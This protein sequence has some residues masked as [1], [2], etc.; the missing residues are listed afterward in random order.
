MPAS[1]PTPLTATEPA[2]GS[3][4]DEALA[5]AWRHVV[6]ASNTSFLQGMRVLPP[7][8]RRAMYAIYAFCRE[9]DDIADEP[10][11]IDDKR[12]RLAEWRAEIDRLFAGRPTAP[13]ARALAAPVAAYGLRREDFLDL[14]DGMEM[15]AVA[16]IVAPDLATLELYC[17]RVAGAVGRLSIRAFGAT[18]DAALDV[19]RELGQ[20]LQ[21]TNILR[22]LAEDAARGRLYLPRE[23]LDEAGIDAADPA[24]ALAH[25][26]LGRVAE[27]M[28]A[29]A[30]RRYGAAKA[31]MARCA[32]RP[33]R[34]ARLMMGAYEAV[35][36]RLEA[37]GWARPAEPVSLPK[38]RKL[39][40]L[41]RHW[42]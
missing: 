37:R 36:A 23:W 21:L 35:L 6:A 42:F 13:T 5:A 39:A 11:P 29:L 14:I 7:P 41:A 38:W 40:V 3:G 24:V 15:D 17:D 10:A 27:R 31:F 16:D 9:V 34:P 30:R 28:T 33:M 25:P 19:A 4:A 12:R 18:E 32:R 2:P 22:D 8:R 26:A 20:A 1:P